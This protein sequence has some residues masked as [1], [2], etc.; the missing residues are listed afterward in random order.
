MLSHL[1]PTLDILDESIRLYRRQFLG[2]VV[3]S[4]ICLVPIIIIVGLS[5]AAIKFMGDSGTLIVLLAWAVLTMPIILFFVGS[6]SRA[7]LMV[8]DEDTIRTREVLAIH[9]LRIMGMGCYGTVFYIILN[10]ISTLLSMFCF[11]PISSALGLVFSGAAGIFGGNGGFL[12]DSIMIITWIIS[13]ILFVFL[14]GLLLAFNGATYSS[15]IYAIQPFVQHHMSFGSTLKQS[16]ELILYRF[17]QNLLGFML[18]SIIF[19]AVAISATIAIGALFPLP[20]IW[21]LGGDSPIAQIGSGIAWLVA[22]ILV[23]PPLPI[24]MALLYQNNLKKYDGTTLE[25]RIAEAV[26]HVGTE[27]AIP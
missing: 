21:I 16:R 11:C 20:L 6:L 2:F 17:G 13:A 3:L 26:G 14:Y 22:F 27:E 4:A 8:R 7:A 24:S 18:S 10:I 19:A 12:G 9:P 5:F 15:V 23:L 25:A 1:Q